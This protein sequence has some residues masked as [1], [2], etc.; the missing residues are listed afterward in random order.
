MPDTPVAPELVGAVWPAAHPGEDPMLYGHVDLQPR[1]AFEARSVQTFRLVYTVGRYG[2]DDTG[3]IRVMFRF[4][5][6]QGDLQTDNPTGY[7]YVSAHTSTGA[8]IRLSYGGTAGQRPW[9]KALTAKLH[10]GYLREGDTI[11]VVFGDTTQG[12]PGMKLQTFCESGFEFKVGADVCAV[13]HYVPLVDTPSIA[14]VPGPP[15]V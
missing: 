2:I 6:D 7:N 4:F 3:G 10:G 11:T 8:K 13:G 14:I 1:G 12:S 5:G 9:F 15:A